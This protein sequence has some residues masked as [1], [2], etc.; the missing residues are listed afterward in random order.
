MFTVPESYTTQF[1]TRDGDRGARWLAGLPALADRYARRW[2]LRPDGP[3]MHGFVG[4]VWPVRLADDTPAVLKISWPNDEG[5]DEAT[6]LA[7]WAGDGAVRLLD[8]DDDDY[9]LLLERLDSGRCLDDEPVDEATAIAGQ[10]FHRLSVP[11]PA[12]SRRRLTDLAVTWQTSLPATAARLGDPVPP[13]LL[14]AAVA[15]C[16]ELGPAAGSSLV[17]E[18]MHYFN[19]LRAE[20]EPWLLIDPKVL[21]GDPEFGVIPMLWNRYTE[22]GGA[23]GIQAKFDAF[24]EAASLDRDL[25]R[26][27]TLV[28]AVGNWLYGLGDGVDWLTEV[29]AEIAF[30]MADPPARHTRS[31][32]GA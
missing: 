21:A 30:R 31:T 12:S 3:S 14:A 1:G 26:G 2:S 15:T 6:A 27:W 5:V 17:N 29:C 13:R 18:D 19:V 32:T 16:R 25:A 4:V 22:T 24:T 20:R 11:A 7:T 28:R 9:A 23:Q 10:L 8:H